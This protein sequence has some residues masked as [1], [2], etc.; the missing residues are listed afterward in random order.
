MISFCVEV[1]PVA[2]V[3]PARRGPN[4]QIPEGSVPLQMLNFKPFL[5]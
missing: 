5:W 3:S 1:R 2:N 4:L